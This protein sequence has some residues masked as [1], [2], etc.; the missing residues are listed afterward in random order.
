MSRHDPVITLRQM[1]DHAREAAEL[2]Q[3]RSRADL[4]T[5]RVYSLAIT[6]L[7]EIL[8]EAA[9]RFPREERERIPAIP[10]P[11][12]VGLRDRIIH[13]YDVVDFDDVWDVLTT[14]LAPLIAALEEALGGGWSPAH[15]DP[16]R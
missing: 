10:W 3:G 11:K 1:L 4:D 5:D 13:G 14:D 2:S 12:V 7:L 15:A 6:R 8:G 9:R 16:R